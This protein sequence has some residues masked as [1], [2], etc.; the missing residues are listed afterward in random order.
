MAD[1]L[2]V[3]ALDDADALT[4]AVAV[5][6]D[7]LADVLGELLGP[8]GEEDESMLPV[9]VAVAEVEGVAVGVVVGV[10]DVDVVGEPDV[11][12]GVDDVAGA[13]GVVDGLEDGPAPVAEPVL[14]AVAA[15]V[16]VV[17]AC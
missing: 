10:E 17:R 5:P 7:A 2:S 12:L 8:V 3:E 16:V 13:V 1:A 11:P 6:V 14:D 4:A 9:G 15:P